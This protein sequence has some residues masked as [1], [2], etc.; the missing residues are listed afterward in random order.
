MLWKVR[1]IYPL[2][3]SEFWV[4][5]PSN[6]IQNSATKTMFRQPEMTS[7]CPTQ[8]S[9]RNAWF[10]ALNLKLWYLKDS[11]VLFL[12][13]WFGFPHPCTKTTTIILARSEAVFFHYQHPERQQTASSSHRMFECCVMRLPQGS[14]PSTLCLKWVLLWVAKCWWCRYHQVCTLLNSPVSL[15]ACWTT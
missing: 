13:L 5:Q 10:I 6:H 14:P 3:Y 12:V 9:V 8:C 11:L 4:V 7:D 1:K 15:G 2:K